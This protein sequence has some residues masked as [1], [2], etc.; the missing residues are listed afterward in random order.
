[1]PCMLAGYTHDST[2][3]WRIWD[4]HFHVVQAQLEGIFD[5]SG[6][7]TFHAPQM[8]LIFLDCQKMYSKLRNFILQMN[9]AACKT[10]EVEM[11][12]SEHRTRQLKWVEIGFSIPIARIA[13]EQAMATGVVM[14]ARL[15]MTEMSIGICLMTIPIEVSLHVKV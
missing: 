8:E 10:L 9:F 11:D 4:P 2:A 1:M 3:L 5:K 12:I 7:H 15:M 13:V 14:M 6:M